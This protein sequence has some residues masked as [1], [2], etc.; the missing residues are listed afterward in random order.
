MN[1]ALHESKP[2]EIDAASDPRAALY[3]ELSNGLHALVQP[4]TIV[5]GALGALSLGQGIAPEHA[6][7]LHMSSEQVDRMCELMSSLQNLLETSQHDADCVPVD[8]WE[9]IEPMIESLAQVANDS[10]VRIAARKPHGVMHAIADPSRTEQAI[11]AALKTAVS[12]AERGDVIQ[13]KLLP[14]GG[15]IDAT[16][17]AGSRRGKGLSSSDRLSL[18]LAQMSIQSQRGMYDC[19]ENPLRISLKLPL[20]GEEKIRT[21]AEFQCSLIEQSAEQFS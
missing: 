4:L 21:G 20:Q 13:L 16:I 8:M 3:S 1:Y 5:R 2:E 14:C 6:R 9:L 18:A 7:Y 10:G 15:F 19:S 12:V 17:Q 11:Q